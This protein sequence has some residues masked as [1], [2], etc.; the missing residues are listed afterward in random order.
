MSKLNQPAVLFDWDMYAQ[1]QHAKR[2][3]LH[4]NQEGEAHAKV[5]C[6]NDANIYYHRNIL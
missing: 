2:E 4:Q 5:A 6:G 1:V 3:V